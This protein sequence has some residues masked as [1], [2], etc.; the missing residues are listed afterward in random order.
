MSKCPNP[1]CDET[2]KPGNKYCSPACTSD[3]KQIQRVRAALDGN[4]E[5]RELA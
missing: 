2:L 1:C 5:W 4:E 3:H